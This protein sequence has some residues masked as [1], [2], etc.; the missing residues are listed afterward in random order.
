[1]CFMITVI[2]AS[3]VYIVIL[4]RNN[5]NSYTAYLVTNLKNYVDGYIGGIFIIHMNMYL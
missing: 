5:S 1:M 4:Y 3:C 2:Q